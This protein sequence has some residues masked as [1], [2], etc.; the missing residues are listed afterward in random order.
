MAWTIA[1]LL[2]GR[3]GAAIDFDPDPPTDDWSRLVWDLLLDTAT[4]SAPAKQVG[5]VGPRG[6]VT[7]FLAN[8]L[9]FLDQPD[10]AGMVPIPNEPGPGSE[11]F[12]VIHFEV[13]G[14]GAPVQVTLG[15]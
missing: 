12:G 5:T 3:T 14:V 11:G 7:L 6:R 13:G 1:D 4:R 10:Q 2:T 8:G 9:R 15:E